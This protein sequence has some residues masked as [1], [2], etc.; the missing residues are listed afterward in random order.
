M[1]TKLELFYKTKDV[2]WWRETLFIIPIEDL[3]KYK[4]KSETPPVD[5]TAE[6]LD[7]T[8][9]LVEYYRNSESHLMNKKV[10]LKYALSFFD[11]KS[12]EVTRLFK[13]NKYT[14]L[15]YILR[16]IFGSYRHEIPNE[17]I[18]KISNFINLVKK[19]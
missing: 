3:K 16:P 4:L 14:P 1:K 17:I 13:F 9:I 8:F 6:T 18:D 15:D 19:V 7:K 10:S 5:L 11:K 12:D 2:D